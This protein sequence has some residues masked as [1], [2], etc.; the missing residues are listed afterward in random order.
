MQHECVLQDER[1]E[2]RA[3]GSDAAAAMEPK[4][5]QYEK[6]RLGLYN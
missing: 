5:V 4:R 1:H 3:S 6:V 2:W